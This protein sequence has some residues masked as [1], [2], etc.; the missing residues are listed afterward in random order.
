MIPTDEDGEL[1]Y[2]YLENLLQKYKS[3]NSL[4]IGSFTAASNITG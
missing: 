3:H 2:K 4:K 1:N